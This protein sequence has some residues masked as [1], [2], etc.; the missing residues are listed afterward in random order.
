MKTK[1]ILFGVLADEARQ[2]LINIDNA[3]DTDTLIKKVNELYPGFRKYNFVVAKN[4]KI[5]KSN[6]SLVES[7]TIALLPPFSGG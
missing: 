2:S 7:D 6:Q 5:I 1:V 3:N 4:K